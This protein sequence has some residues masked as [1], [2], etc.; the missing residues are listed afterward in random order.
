MDDS[1]NEFFLIDALSEGADQ[2]QAVGESEDPQSRD[3]GVPDPLNGDINAGSDN[4]NAESTKSPHN[5]P[6]AMLVF[7]MGEHRFS[8]SCDLGVLN[9]HPKALKT[10]TSNQCL[11]TSA[12]LNPALCAVMAELRPWMMVQVAVRLTAI[13]LR[14]VA[15]VLSTQGFLAQHEGSEGVE[16]QK[17]ADIIRRELDSALPYYRWHGPRNYNG[18]VQY[19][20]ALLEEAIRMLAVPKQ[21]LTKALE[22]DI[23]A[24]QASHHVAR[25]IY[26]LGQ[27]PADVCG[28]W[29]AETLLLP[30][31]PGK[32]D[33]KSAADGDVAART[34]EPVEVA[35]EKDIGTNHQST[36]SKT[37]SIGEEICTSQNPRDLTTD[38]SK[39]VANNARPSTSPS[40]SEDELPPLSK[41]IR[42][43]PDLRA[44]KKLSRVEVPVLKAAHVETNVCGSQAGKSV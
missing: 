19:L 25:M 26:D 4:A 30:Q 3:T 15:E 5:A 16:Y 40:E 36:S 12:F 17:L 43:K 8:D 1:V 33:S 29:A 23:P 28:L 32:A 44:C 13:S 20:M 27:S 42:S 22:L 2:S 34:E 37:A 9:E 14:L 7:V 6:Q 11:S 21:S 41:F 38:S 31:A 24:V 18:R 39:V 10:I 35:I